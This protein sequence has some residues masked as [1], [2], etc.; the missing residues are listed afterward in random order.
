MENLQK[1]KKK[2]NQVN[3]Y[4]RLRKPSLTQITEDNLKSSILNLS[5]LIYRF[6]PIS[7][8]IWN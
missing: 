4:K 8:Q 1:F 3:C 5:L 7:L 2:T 6:K